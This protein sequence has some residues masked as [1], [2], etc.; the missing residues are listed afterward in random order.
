MR[1]D[2]TGLIHGGF[3]FSLADY[4]AMLAVN[5]PNVV[6]GSSEVKFIKPA[7][8]GQE[9]IA[10]GRITEKEGKKFIVH[11]DVKYEDSI[12]FQGTFI[13]YTP[14]EHVLKRIKT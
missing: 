11:V 14:E 1:T 3:I 7:V 13:C 12:I 4:A 5:H 9:L 6:L 10:E 8:S 2:D